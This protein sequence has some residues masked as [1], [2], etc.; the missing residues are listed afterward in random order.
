MSEGT[1]SEEYG[2]LGKI[3]KPQ[4][5]AAAILGCVIWCIVVQEQNALSQFALPFTQTSPFV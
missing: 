5:V 1:K 4:S 3:S 2:E